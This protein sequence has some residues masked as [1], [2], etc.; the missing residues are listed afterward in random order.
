MEC[1]SREIIRW[2]L[3]CSVQACRGIHIAA[4]PYAR[5]CTRLMVNEGTGFLARDGDEWMATQR[6]WRFGIKLK[7]CEMNLCTCAFGGIR[8]CKRIGMQIHL[9]VSLY[10]TS[11]LFAQRSIGLD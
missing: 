3:T 7:R 8:C 6:R 11:L 10:E 4:Q 2:N 9:P 5:A 1:C